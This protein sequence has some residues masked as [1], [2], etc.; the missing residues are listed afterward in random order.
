MEFHISRQSRD[1]YEFDQSLFS[2]SGNVIFANLRA[3]R[4]F[5]QKINQRRDVIRHPERAVRAGELNA[6]GLIDEILHLVVA[7]YRQERAPQS[8]ALALDWLKQTVGRRKV[9]RALVDFATDFPPLAVYRGELSL[10]EYLVGD[11]D[12]VPN[13]EVLLEEMLLL[14]LENKNPAF[15]PFQELFDDTRLA[16]ESAYAPVMAE[17]HRFFEHQPPF[18]PQEQNLVDLLRSPA[19]AVPHSLSGQIEYIR[20]NWADLL[21]RYLS[22]LL[23]RLLTSLDLIREEEMQRGM[24]GGGPIPVPVYDAAAMAFEAENFS[25]DREWMPRLVLLAKNTYVWL[26]QLSQEYG[27]EIKRLDQIPDEELR[28]LAGW[29]FTGLWLIGLWERSRASARIKQIMGNAEAIASAYSLYDYS[30]AGDLGGEEAYRALREKAWR[31]GIRLAS[32]MVPNHMGIDSPWVVEHPD[33][34][35][36]LDYSPF[37]SYSFNSENLSGDDRAVIQIEDHYYSRS[38]AAVVFRHIDRRDGHER[39]IYH[40]NDGTSMPWND[41]AQL[42]YFKPEVR[43]AVIQTILSVARRFPIIR[44]DAAMTLAKLHFQRLWFPTPGTGGAIPSRADFSMSKEQ[45]DQ[46]MPVEFWREVVDRVAQEAPDT[47]LLAEAFWLMESYFVRTLGMHR[48]YNSAFM[49]ILRNEE[50]GKYRLIMKNTLEFDPEILKRYVNFMNN[51]DERTAVDQFGKGDKYF[52]ICTL[53]ATMPGLPMIGHG[54]IEGY[55]EKYGM[56][57]KRAYWDERP[58]PYLIERHQREIFPL[59]HRRALF[60]GVDNFLLYDFFT[61]IGGVNE[62]VY[63]Y[64]N[65]LGSERGLVVYHN[66]FAD[67][68]GWV[69]MSAAFSL[70]GPDGERS[71]TQRSLGEGLNLQ[72]GPG[73]YCIYRDL[74]SG[75][76]YIRASQEIVEKGLFLSLHAYEYHAFV[77]IHEVADD[78]WS[79]YGKLNAYLAGR[80]VPS[81]QSALQELQLQPVLDPLRGILNSGYLRYLLDARLREPAAALPPDL[82]DEGE[83]KLSHLLDGIEYMTGAGG[84]GAGMARSRLLQ[85]LRPGLRLA[86][87]LPTLAERYPLP[88]ASRYCRAVEYL[89]AGLPE[90]E[91][92]GWLALFAWLFLHDLGRLAGDEDAEATT[93]AWIDEWM[94]G[95][96]LSEAAR[97]LGIPEERIHELPGLLK[98][99]VSQQHW[100]DRLSPRPAAPK[101]AAEKAAPRQAAPAPVEGTALPTPGAAAPA[102]ALPGTAAETHAVVQSALATVLE[103]WLSDEEIQRYLKINRYEDVLWFDKDRFETFVWWM[104]AL[105]VFDGAASPRAGAALLVERML[106]VIDIAGK[107]L[108]AEEK[109]GYQIEKLLKA[110]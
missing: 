55:S 59:L 48:V 87:S 80:G 64:S 89:R 32:D 74:T 53:L 19:I 27:R 62:D 23:G 77:D 60:A 76:E 29:G 65:G 98:L 3:A 13:Q 58:D 7:I 101:P 81:V 24:G 54:Q 28:K 17:L 108:K 70:K 9:E 47:L 68:E 20:T 103:A 36:S 49:N 31:V 86:L 88:G 102:Q 40:G 110:V 44:F 45:F 2:L 105:A 96:L 46:I 34:F 92:G 1:R 51:P 97:E 43:E 85:A 73:R 75:L 10:A 6:M 91:S 99:L 84:D 106:L 67:T 78:E 39:F 66:K 71:L 79:S 25:P 56:E 72:G 52:G 63:V 109:S 90:Q 69:R 12:G 38:D 21:G 11:T 82:L 8:L 18:G 14:W 16:A 83:E 95:R 100:Y 30:I 104:A 94:I 61:T 41:T 26:A 57:F 107:L 50:N 4:T 22:S 42:N 5:A 93:S 15:S 35:L 33:W 37:P